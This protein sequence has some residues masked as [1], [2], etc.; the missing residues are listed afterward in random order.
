MT[1]SGLKRSM[2]CFDLSAMSTGASDALQVLEGKAKNEVFPSQLSSMGFSSLI[3]SAKQ[4]P[5][6]SKR[7]KRSDASPATS[8]L[9]EALKQLEND[10]NFSNIQPLPSA[11]S[12]SLMCSNSSNRTTN[13]MIMSP[14]DLAVAEKT[15]FDWAIQEEHS[16]MVPKSCT[17]EAVG[18]VPSERAAWALAPMRSA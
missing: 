5:S 16:K 13:T 6:V 8:A 7:Q 18:V 2:P 10:K 15:S 17:N 12:S 14:F 3:I 9:E 11:T 1:I 4:T